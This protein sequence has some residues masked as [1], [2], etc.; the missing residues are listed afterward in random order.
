MC[1]RRTSWLPIWRSRRGSDLGGASRPRAAFAS[2]LACQI[3]MVIWGG[4]IPGLLTF[5]GSMKSVACASASFVSRRWTAIGSA[6]SRVGRNCAQPLA[7][8][9]RSNVRPNASMRTNS[10]RRG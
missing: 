10:T 2:G 5:D 1:F 3:L 7:V 9:E 6:A 8:R 4:S